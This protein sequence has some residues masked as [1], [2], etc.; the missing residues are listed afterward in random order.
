MFQT[1]NKIRNIRRITENNFWVM[2]KLLTRHP[3]LCEILEK[4]HDSQWAKKIRGPLNTMT[5]DFQL[6]TNLCASLQKKCSS[7]TPNSSIFHHSPQRDYTRFYTCKAGRIYTC[8]SHHSKVPLVL[9][10]HFLHLFVNALGH[11]TAAG[12]D[13]AQPNIPL[14][15]KP[16]SFTSWRS[17]LLKGWR[18]HR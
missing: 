8:I 17:S 16:V 12:S 2:L 13:V 7:T 9:A 14:A 11:L 18:K 10:A 4:P 3:E 5:A 6:S 1:T 15:R